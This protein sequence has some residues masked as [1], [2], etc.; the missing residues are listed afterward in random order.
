MR[1]NSGREYMVPSMPAKRMVDEPKNCLPISYA[2]SL[3]KSEMMKSESKR[4]CKARKDWKRFSYSVTCPDAPNR[5]RS[6]VRF[7]VLLKG[8]ED[9]QSTL[10]KEF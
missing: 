2:C 8:D 10:N 7:I 4:S 1:S 5:S 6:L 3:L 9:K